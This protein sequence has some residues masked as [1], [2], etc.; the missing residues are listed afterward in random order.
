MMNVSGY[1]GM[2][3][4]KVRPKTL[5]R[6]GTQFVQEYGGALPPCA[7]EMSPASR[8]AAFKMLRSSFCR[9]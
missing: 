3:S 8:V 1:H 7:V 9:V 5:S 4:F 2:P 6:H